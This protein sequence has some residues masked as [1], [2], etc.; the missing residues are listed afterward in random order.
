MGI[1][2]LTGGKLKLQVYCDSD[3]AGDR[4]DRKST[5]GLLAQLDGTSI[6]WRT[7]KQGVV[8]LSTTEAEF[9]ALSE[10]TKL[11]VWL[12]HLLKKIVTKPGQQVS[13]RITRE[14]SDGRQMEYGMQSM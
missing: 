1:R 11:T 9:C 4:M 13:W 10:A 14:L 3:W 5:T 8:A 12:R 6:T 2:S 7:L